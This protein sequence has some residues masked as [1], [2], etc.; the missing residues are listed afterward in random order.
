MGKNNIEFCKTILLKSQLLQFLSKSHF[1][2][3]ADQC[4]QNV[5]ETLDTFQIPLKFHLLEMNS[6]STIKDVMLIY[7]YTRIYVIKHQVPQSF[8]CMYEKEIKYVHE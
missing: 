3:L 2:L 6:L 7:K 4:L 8:Y 1:L 5:T